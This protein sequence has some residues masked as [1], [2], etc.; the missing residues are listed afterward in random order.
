MSKNNDSTESKFQAAA[1]VSSEFISP[2]RC[3]LRGMLLSVAV[4]CVVLAFAVNIVTEL[5]RVKQGVADHYA[6]T[7]VTEMVSHYRLTNGGTFPTSWDDMRADYTF[8][9]QSYSLGPAGF[10]QLQRQVSIN[11]ELLSDEEKFMQLYRNPGR[12]RDF[13]LIRLR[14]E[15]KSHVLVDAERS[16]DA[17][18]KQLVWRSV[19]NRP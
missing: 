13:W 9:D 11:F 16:A 19:R 18:L 14:N 8:V 10:E 5:H 15:Q 2:F 17:R 6:L 12:L 3:S 4:V 7:E 1:P